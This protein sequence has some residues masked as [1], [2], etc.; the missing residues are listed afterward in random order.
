MADTQN[1]LQHLCACDMP[2]LIVGAPWRLGDGRLINCAVAIGNHRVLGMIPK[3]F[4]QI[5]ANTMNS[6]GSRQAPALTKPR[7]TMPSAPFTY[8]LISCFDWATP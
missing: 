2:L 7:Y 1:A 5:T 4:C 3:T 6:V 8:A